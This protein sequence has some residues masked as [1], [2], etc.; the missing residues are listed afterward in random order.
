MHQASRSQP[1]RP[2]ENH[3][4]HLHSQVVTEHGESAGH[5]GGSQFS[6]NPSCAGLLQGFPYIWGKQARRLLT[7]VHLMLM[8]EIIN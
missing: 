2:E 1:N 5:A 4:L 7:A 6:T 8:I 3:R